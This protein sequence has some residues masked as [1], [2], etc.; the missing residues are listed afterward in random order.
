MSTWTVEQLDALPIGTR[1][2]IIVGEV[3]Y[4]VW[5]IDD[6]GD[7]WIGPGI[8]W[9]SQDLVDSRL[10]DDTRV[11]GLPVEYLF[12][13]LDA[14]DIRAITANAVARILKAAS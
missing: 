8:E 4:Q 11:A 13:T 6:E 7:C 1:I 14:G 9:S 5:R 12:P 2:E 10:T 3:A